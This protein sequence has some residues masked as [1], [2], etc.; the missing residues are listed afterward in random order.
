MQSELAALEARINAILPPRYVGCFE[1]VPAASMGTASLKYDKQGKVAWGE[2]WTTFCH[3][4]LA[5]GPPHRGSFLAAVPAAEALA[6]PAEQAAIVA[7]IKRAIRLSANLRALDTEP[8]GWVCLRCH[9]ADMAAWL[10]RA[11]VAENVIARHEGEILFVPAG[12][13]FR[14]EKEIK[15]VVVSV[16]KSCHYLLD[17]VEPE[18]RPRGFPEDLIEPPLPEAIAAAP[19][20]HLAATA[21]LRATITSQSGL[22]TTDAQSPGWIGLQCTSE[23]MAIWLQRAT[24]VENIL[25]RREAETLF[26]P[27]SISSVKGEALDRVAMAVS[28]A[29]RLWQV[30]TS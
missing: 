28:K 11:I 27:V 5:G 30:R 15:N 19:Q 26:V 29:V 18:E 16:A 8:P 20:Q 21:A 13:K 2:I 14:I 25:A 9:D 4:A 23:E 6:H 7:E 17:H 22:E 1:D 12:P 10:V 3:L 24:I